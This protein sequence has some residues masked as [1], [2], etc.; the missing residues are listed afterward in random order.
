MT[1]VDTRLGGQG[2]GYEISGLNRAGTT[3]A[4][5]W[6]TDLDNRF[7][8]FKFKAN[9]KEAKSEAEVASAAGVVKI[10]GCENVIYSVDI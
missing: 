3:V 8:R 10:W 2:K 6:W 1:Y 9:A 7:N 4:R 5:W